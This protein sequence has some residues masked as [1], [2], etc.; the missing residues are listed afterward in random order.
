[1][2]NGPWFK[3]VDE[4]I[5]ACETMIC[6]LLEKVPPDRAWPALIRYHQQMQRIQS[7]E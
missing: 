1:M 3:T 7:Q 2:G 5:Y 4:H 6:T